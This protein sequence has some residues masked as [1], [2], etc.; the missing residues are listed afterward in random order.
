MPALTVAGTDLETAFGFFLSDE[1]NALDTGVEVQPEV[2]IPGVVGAFLAGPPRV[3]PK[4]FTLSGFLEAATAAEVHENLR[5]LQDWLRLGLAPIRLGDRP[6]LTID[7]RPVAVRPRAMHPQHVQSVIDVDIVVRA[8]FP[9]WR[10]GEALAYWFG[11]SPTRMPQ[12]SAPV[13]PDFWIMAVG[14]TA[15]NP[16]LKGYD[17][18]GNE[19]WSATFATLNGGEAYRIVTAGADMAIWK[20]AGS[21]TPTLSDTSLT[22]GIFPQSFASDRQSYRFQQWPALSVSAGVGRAVYPRMFA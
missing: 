7:A 17:A 10:E 8:P 15:T 19:L 3:A 4:E 9:Y 18:L 13:A 21:S 5:A 22:A 1:T 16:Q 6:T 12:G 11:S 20:Y 2:E 14:G